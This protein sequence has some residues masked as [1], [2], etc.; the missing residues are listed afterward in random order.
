MWE[1][2]YRLAS[3][4][5]HL[6]EKIRE[7]LQIPP[8]G[9]EMFHA[10]MTPEERKVLKDKVDAEK[11]E[12]LKKNKKKAKTPDEEAQDLKII[13]E[14]IEEALKHKCLSED[15]IMGKVEDSV[16][17]LIF[18]QQ[19]ETHKK[20]NSDTWDDLYRKYSI[21]DIPCEGKNV[22]VRLDLDVPLSEYVPP[23]PEDAVEE[24]ET[25]L[26][27]SNIS[28]KDGLTGWSKGGKQTSRSKTTSKTVETGKPSKSKGKSEFEAEQSTAPIKKEPDI[29]LTRTILDQTLIRKAIPTIKHIQDSLGLRT[30]IAGNLQEITGKPIPAN[31]MKFVWNAL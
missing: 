21:L 6:D 18:K 4:I 12:W 20:M 31:T 11:A 26:N 30:F 14:K 16:N 23:P 22:L 13:K 5:P 1:V 3:E 25:K 24:E 29:L 10:E 8:Y 19:L 17:L 28:G 27:K 15:H 7:E 9:F 2:V